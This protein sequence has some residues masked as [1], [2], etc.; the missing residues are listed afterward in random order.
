M[1]PSKDC[2][3]RRKDEGKL[4]EMVEDEEEGEMGWDFSHA[5]TL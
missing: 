1:A 2:V 4:V 3:E 5:V